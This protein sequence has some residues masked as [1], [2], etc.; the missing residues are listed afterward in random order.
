MRLLPS[1]HPKRMPWK[2]G[3]GSTLELVTD[4]REDGTFTW[5]LAL[6]DVPEP[7]PFS[8]YPGLDRSIVLVA[9]AGLTLEGPEGV[10]EVP[11]L[12]LGLAFAGEEP[13]VAT[14]RGPSVRDANLMMARARW[15]GAVQH[16]RDG[17]HDLEGD[18]VIAHA[19][20]GRVVAVRGKVRTT[21]A[22][23]E[24]LVTSGTVR[25][26]CEDGSALVAATLRAR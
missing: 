12:G 18:V 3:R 26:S 23:G 24:T 20:S 10:R 16:R 14:P 13:V 6:A 17:A 1:S 9:G 15:T 21:L 25:A 11:A 22:S 7:G 4:A 5:R 8:S 2:N 19:L